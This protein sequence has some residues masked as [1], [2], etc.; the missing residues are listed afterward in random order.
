[1]L[2]RLVLAGVFL[3]SFAKGIGFLFRSDSMDLLLFDAAGV[4]WMFYALVF[5]MVV[6]L[7][8]SLVWLW[9]PFPGGRRFAFAAVFINFIETCVAG[10]IGFRDPKLAADAFATSRV[11][12]SLEVREEVLQLMESPSMHFIPIAISTVFGAFLILM[13]CKVNTTLGDDEE[14]EELRNC[15][16]CGRQMAAA[17]RICPRCEHRVVDQSLPETA[18]APIPQQAEAPTPEHPVRRTSTSVASV[19]TVVDLRRTGKSVSTGR[20]GVRT[21]PVCG[22]EVKGTIC[23]NGRCDWF[24]K[25]VESNADQTSSND[26]T[27]R[28]PL[29]HSSTV[30]AERSKRRVARYRPTTSWFVWLQASTLTLL[31]LSLATIHLAVSQQRILIDI[32]TIQ[33]TQFDLQ[34]QE[35]FT[36]ILLF[37]L[38]LVTI[39][40][41]V[42]MAGWVHNSYRNLEALRAERVSYSP[43]GAAIRTLLPIVGV[44]TMW[45]VLMELWK[46][47]DPCRITRRDVVARFQSPWLIYVLFVLVVGSIP[48]GAYALSAARS[49]T[50][51]EAAVHLTNIGLACDV[52]GCL[53][54]LVLLLIVNQVT[55]NQAARYAVVQEM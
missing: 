16:N 20:P 27:A 55:R 25:R 48:L 13:I 21:C 42:A 22:T 28:Q 36:A 43:A 2:I 41:I 3:W 29:Q 10:A 33:L 9:R 18:T 15:P 30:R 53:H 8:V 50:N 5:L 40:F 4:K 46:G 54:T 12:R 26:R 23:T 14:Q 31:V 49:V 39:A 47:S 24:G 17:T 7:A 38:L 32:D 45:P 35:L 6:C 11:S 37:A 52:V 44:F 51:M 1:M 19:S 34:Q